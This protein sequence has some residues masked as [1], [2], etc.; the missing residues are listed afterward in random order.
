MAY[1]VDVI[2]FTQN[3]DLRLS[4][5]RETEHANLIGDM[6]PRARGALVLETLAQ[7]LA[8][9]DDAAT[10]GA[11]VI[12][13]HG[14]QLRIVEDAAG[15]VG[16]VGGRV[17]DFGALQDGE[18]GRHVVSGSAGVGPGGREE[19]KD[20][21]ALAVEPE[22]LGEGLGDDHFEALVDEV[23]DGPG[24]AD[25]IPGGKTLVGAVKEG[26][27][28][29]LAHDGGN[30]LP[31]VLGRV[32]AGR[33][34]SAGMQQDD[35][36][37][38]GGAQAGDHAIEVETLGLGVEVGVLHDGQAHAAKDLVVVGPGRVGEVDGRRLGMEAREEESPQMDGASARDG[39]EGGHAG[40][41]NGRT[42]RAHEQFLRAGGEVG[43]PLDIEVLVEG[44]DAED[45]FLGLQA[46]TFTSS[47]LFYYIYVCVCV[48]S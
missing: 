46:S 28:V 37:G 14:K 41:P 27:V 9:V 24:I 6:L 13:P 1:H 20:A 11:Q 16:A 25:Q 42:V 39:L 32:D 21:R 29:A 38:R 26:E 33:V 12:L 5:A 45:G 8:H 35:G 23:A 43:Q 4:Q 7:T 2:L 44:R 34:M 48:Y 31:L 19:V 47:S 30:A 22:V 40:V 10:H 18:L 3:L 15:D 36:A 17:G